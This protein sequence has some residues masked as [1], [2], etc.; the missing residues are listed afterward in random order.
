M[1]YKYGNFYND[2]FE[3][4]TKKQPQQRILPVEAV[5]VRVFITGFGCDKSF[6]KENDD[7]GYQ[8]EMA[9][10]SHTTGGMDM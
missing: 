2:S 9:W 6:E 4:K 5:M 1:F 10:H 7:A 3:I 8:Y